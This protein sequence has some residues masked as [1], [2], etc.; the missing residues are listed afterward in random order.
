MGSYQAEGGRLWRRSRF[1]NMKRDLIYFNFYLY[2][3][4]EKTGLGFK[5]CEMRCIFF[6]FFDAIRSLCEGWV[7]WDLSFRGISLLQ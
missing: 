6:I 1:G 7:S 5:N 3:F 2:F 4:L